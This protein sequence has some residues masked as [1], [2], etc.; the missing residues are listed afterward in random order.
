ME[1]DSGDRWFGWPQA[2]LTVNGCHIAYRRGGTTGA[3]P[4]VLVHGGGGHAG[5]WVEVAPLLGGTYDVVIPDLSGHGDSGHRLTYSPQVW[6]DELA[7]LLMALELREVNVVAHSMG[8]RV[9]VFLASRWPEL[10][11]RLVLVDTY[12]R[13]PVTDGA[14]RRGRTRSR[15][16]VYPD[17]ESAVRA[18]Q[19]RPPETVA[20]A[21]LLDFVARS[22]VRA[23]DG[24]WTWKFDQRYAQRFTDEMLDDELARVSCAV[25]LI[26]GSDSDLVPEAM[27]PYVAER[28]GRPIE[29]VP[30]SPAFHHVPLDA[31]VAC[32]DAIVKLCA[33]PT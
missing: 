14:E 11:R 1:T 8:G 12:L 3:E 4:I 20:D 27:L 15:K 28:L 9:S 26:H 2:G 18:F 23:V 31:P 24:G 17:L 6:A 25:S 7:G 10:V 22:S 21:G 19:L 33:S 30:V 13:R 29:A 32:A 16:R 5:W